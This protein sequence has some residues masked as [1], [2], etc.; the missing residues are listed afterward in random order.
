[1]SWI[2]SVVNSFAMTTQL[3]DYRHPE[4]DSGSIQFDGKA[5]RGKPALIDSGSEPG[6]TKNNYIVVIL[7][8]LARKNP[9]DKYISKGWIASHTLAMTKNNPPRNQR[10]D[11][12]PRPLWERGRVRGQKVAF[13]LAEVLISLGIIGIVAAMTI[14]TLVTKINE[15]VA[16]HQFR[17]AYSKI[18]QALRLVMSSEDETLPACYYG[19]NFHSSGNATQCYDFFEKLTQQMKVVQVCKGNAYADGCIPKYKG[20]DDISLERNPN[21]DLEYL[22]RNCGGYATNRILNASYAYVLIDGT[23][24]FTY[25]AAN[26]PLFAIDINGKTGPN[27]WGYDLFGLGLLEQLSGAVSIYGPAAS[28]CTP[29]EDGGRSANEMLRQIR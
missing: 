15:R 25:G 2:A 8:A 7:R 18:N 21:T 1:K 6:M 17:V 13:T 10:I 24:L 16:N 22:N 19:N 27:R 14:P 23:I 3:Q 5:L 26:T 20:V 9:A 28:S 11:S 12:F 4:L 29:V